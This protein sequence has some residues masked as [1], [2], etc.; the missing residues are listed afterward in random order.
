MT[1]LR[2]VFRGARVGT[3]VLLLLCAYHVVRAAPALA[4]ERPVLAISPHPAGRDA[5]V[6]MSFRS[7]QHCQGDS[8]AGY[9]W[10]TFIT[11]S[12]NDPVRLTYA[13]GLPTGRGF[14]TGLRDST[15]SWIR[16]RNP[17]LTDGQVIP[18]GSVTFEGAA[19]DGMPDGEYLVGIA[20]TKQSSDGVT[21][22]TRA[23]S[24]RVRISSSSSGAFLT[25]LDEPAPP[26]PTPGSTTVAP[27]ESG[28][29]TGTTS[30][31][32]VPNGVA[33]TSVGPDDPAPLATEVA[34]TTVIG[35]GPQRIA[36]SLPKAPE[37]KSSWGLVAGCAAAGAASVVAMFI[38]I[39]QRRRRGV[40]PG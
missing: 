27:E 28:R 37:Q 29:S 33:M 25:L 40:T 8:E 39:R 12:T 1:T 17:G 10:Q 11:P 21:R 15:N 19:Y 24:R 35:A 13:V 16:N 36:A 9:L 26:T 38:V 14:T 2:G 3:G 6:S 18:P 4:D 20:C 5:V 30:T 32:P 7:P 22:T 34:S 31:V 23:W